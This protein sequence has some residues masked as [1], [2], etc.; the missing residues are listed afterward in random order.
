LRDFAKVI[1][2]IGVDVSEH[3]SRALRNAGYERAREKIVENE[4]RCRRLAERLF[5]SGQVS[6]AEF[7]ALMIA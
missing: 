1:E 7:K 5:E 4:I 6:A 2:I 3:Q